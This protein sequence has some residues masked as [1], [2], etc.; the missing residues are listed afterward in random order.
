MNKR[1]TVSGQRAKM[2]YLCHQCL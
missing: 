2:L 1:R